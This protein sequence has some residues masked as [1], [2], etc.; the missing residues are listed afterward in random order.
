[1]RR[2]RRGEKQEN[3]GHQDDEPGRGR[4]PTGPWRSRVGFAPGGFAF[5]PGE[6]LVRQSA[7]DLAQEALEQLLRETDGVDLQRDESPVAEEFV[8]FRGGFDVSTAIRH[9]HS[10]GVLAQVNHVLFAVP[11][12]PPHPARS[13]SHRG[14]PF[15]GT[16]FYGTPFYGTPFYGTAGGCGCGC[17]CADGLGGTPFYG[18]PFY[19]T[20]FYGTADPSPFRNPGTQVDGARRSSARPTEALDEDVLTV[21]GPVRIAV[22]DTGLAETFRPQALDDMDVVGR[23]GDRPDEDGD[24]YL[25]PAS[26]HGTFIAGIIDRRAH[27]C[28]LEVIEVLATQGDGDE[29]EVSTVLTELAR[30]DDPPHVVNLSFGAYAPLGMGALAHAVALLQEVGSIVVAAAGNDAT[31]VPM[32]PAALPGV[33]GVGALDAEGEPAPFT[34]YGPWV[35]ASTLGVDVVSIFF[36]GYDG[37]E[38]PVEGVDPDR[39][40]GWARWSGSSFAAPRVAAALARAIA[41]GVPA[42][43]AVARVVDDPSLPRI[44]MLGTVVDAPDRES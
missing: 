24:G 34:N 44:P 39:F 3:R 20:P 22:L 28:R 33:V 19:G 30:R 40:A 26:G 15:Y 41:E 38:S 16:P 4:R 36:E 1:M 21:A 18:T 11:C 27:G 17:G 7:A 23:G 14:T 31:C 8:R 10:V 13:R 42:S 2:R 29:A 43:D 5:R 25:D 9:L 37:A 35:R 32:Y 6:V 12:C